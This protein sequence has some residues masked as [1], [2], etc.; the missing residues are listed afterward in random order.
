LATPFATANIHTGAIEPMSVLVALA[1]VGDQNA[2]VAAVQPFFQERQQ[3]F[4]FFVAAA[5]KR[6]NMRRPFPPRSSQGRW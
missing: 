5:E 3:D 2:L 4:I 1:I 6:A